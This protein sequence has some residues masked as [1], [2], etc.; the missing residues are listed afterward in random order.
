MR[1]ALVQLACG[2]ALVLAGG[3]VALSAA[4]SAPLPFPIRG[5]AYPGRN[6]PL[7]TVSCLYARD[8]PLIAL[9]GAN[10]VRTYGLV[11]ENDRT[12]QPVLESSGLH[13]LAGF[14][15]DE[16]Y[17]P[18]QTLA[19]REPLILEAFRKYA[20]R[21]RGEK[22]LIGYVFGENV[23]TDHA[24]KFG[25]SPEEF[26]SLLSRAAEILREIDPARTPLLATAVSNPA[27]LTLEIPGLSF[28]CWNASSR[29]L[30]AGIEATRPVVISEDGGATAE[31]AADEFG[32]VYASFADSE[33]GLFRSE[34]TG[35]AGLDTL[36]PRPLYWRLAGLWGGTYPAAWVE[37]DK[38]RLAAPGGTTAAGVLVRLE[39]SS[40]V[41]SVAPYSDES[42]PYHLAGTCLCLAGAP[43]RM[44][45]LS[46]RAV[47]AQIPSGAE[48]GPRLLIFYRAGQASD[49][50]RIDIGEFS[51]V[52]SA[53]PVIEARL[54]PR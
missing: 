14:P 27:E 18:S 16:F 12:F 28:W 19:S 33:A 32:G 29:P 13:W 8:L 43:A 2:L 45:F 11:P 26:Y 31:V 49:P 30:R 48:P 46:P 54:R 51:T 40:L 25:G 1:T 39:G 15:L 23:A 21:F 50:V 35:Q 4:D 37:K 44:S 41:N 34:P 47:T 6:A 9:M 3:P 5:V 17:D 42:W 38:P 24:R 53:G 22:R 7:P 52:T 20:A 10:T 36:S